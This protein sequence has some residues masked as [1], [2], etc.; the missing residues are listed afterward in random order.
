MTN[1]F[2]LAHSV[3]EGAPEA[4]IKPTLSTGTNGSIWNQKQFDFIVTAINLIGHT[5]QRTKF[6]C[7]PWHFCQVCCPFGAPQW[8]GISKLCILRPNYFFFNKWPQNQPWPRMSKPS[9][10][11]QWMMLTGEEWLIRKIISIF[12]YILLTQ[13]ADRFPPCCSFCLCSTALWAAAT[14]NQ[15][16]GICKPLGIYVLC[17]CDS[18]IHKPEKKSSFIFTNLEKDNIR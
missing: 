13:R 4:D 8:K 9:W 10:P 3:A 18:E 14:Q 1:L 12:L 6:K 17:P 16:A 2:H 15:N 11:T 7:H 5:S